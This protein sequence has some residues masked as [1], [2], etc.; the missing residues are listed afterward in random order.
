M[1]KEEFYREALS[2]A[3]GPLEG[4][5]VLEATTSQAGPI[6]G[7]VLADMGA[8]VIKI[9]QPRVG[10]LLRKA[11]P[12]LESPSVLDRSSF[13]MSVNRN[14]KNITLDFRTAQGRKIFFDLIRQMKIDVVIENFKPGTMAKWGLGYEE[15]KAVRPDIVYVSVSGRGQFGPNH[16]KP[17]YDCVGQAEGGLMNVTGQPGDPPTR[18][19][20]GMGDD[21][22]GWQGAFGAM[23]ALV[24][25][26]ETGI[27]Q[28]VD[29]SQQ[30][31]ILYCSDMGIMGTANAG[32]DWKRMGSGNDAVSPYDAYPCQ[33]GYIFIAIVLDSHWMR[34]CQ[35]IGREDLIADPQTQTQTSRALNKPYV[36][37]AVSAW[38]QQRTVDE[39]FKALD[40]IQVVVCPILDLQQILEDR[41]VQERDMIEEVDHPL[42]GKLKVYGVAPKFSLT[43]ARVRSAAPLFGQHNEEIYAGVLDLSAEELVRLQ[44]EGVI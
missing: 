31:T 6:A 18:A 34:F 5:R 12:F 19:G 36:D 33:D 15:V 39:A 40:Q 43:P 14:K 8:E 1:K 41:H 44:E 27:G 10:D 22:A 37:E 2:N 26:S 28:H 17:S 9:D 20:Y 38:T 21:L 16:A 24:Y 7:T 23:A 11:P 29:V 13:H 32:L 42:C 3:V 25:R 30:D 35:V 4:I